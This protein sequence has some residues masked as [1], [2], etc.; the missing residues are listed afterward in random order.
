M[1]RKSKYEADLHCHTSASDGSLTPEGIIEHA[2]KRGLRAIA[3]TDHDTIDG[4]TNAGE[5]A[6]RLGILF[7]KGI[8]INTDWESK[9]VHI[10]GFGM[11]ENNR[12]F[13]DQLFD[14]Q[15]K[16]ILRIKEILEKL[17]RFKID[18]A[19]EDVLQYA[20]GDSIGR[21]HVAQAM[22]KK[23]YIASIKVAFDRYLKIGC[24]AYVPRY[25]LSPTQA[26]KIIRD[27][28]GIPVL[29]HPGVQDLESDISQWVREGLRGI[30]I[31]HPDHSLDDTI[32]YRK[33]AE[34]EDLIPTGGSDYHGPVLKSG[35]ELGD[36]GV[37]LDIVDQLEQ[38]IRQS[39]IEAK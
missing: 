14:L 3:V 9:E 19:F 1:Y 6:K 30:E 10:L 31:T 20:R 34:K 16:R 2:A 21:P 25:K 7:I 4:W 28:G 23:G 22:V 39:Q 12:I 29:A 17:K 11:D 13:K 27:S 8:E 37:G 24:P 32:K 33:I 15:E 36:W 5:A 26:I 35:I 38:M 18:I